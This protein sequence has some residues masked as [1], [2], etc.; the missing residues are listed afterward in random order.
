MLKYK[1][2]I[3]EQAVTEFESACLYY[4]DQLPGLGLEFE[5]EVFALISLI[6]KNLFFFPIKF[7]HIHEAVVNRFPFVINYEVGDK[8]IIVSAVFHCKQDSRKKSKRK[9]KKID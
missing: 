8:E 6:N 9:R 2:L 3:L 5:N 4:N 7:A 1:L